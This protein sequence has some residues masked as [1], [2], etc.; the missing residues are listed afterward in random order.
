MPQLRCALSGKDV[1]DRYLG[2]CW[3]GEVDLNTTMVWSGNAVA[4]V[5]YSHRYLP[6]EIS[7]RLGGRALW[8]TEFTRPDV[9]PRS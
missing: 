3:R 1:Y 6:D 5:Q 8:A 9:W 7:A 2:V 4:Y